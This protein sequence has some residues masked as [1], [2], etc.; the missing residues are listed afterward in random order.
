MSAPTPALPALRTAR[1][2]LV[3][4]SLDHL[5]AELESPGALGRL[6]DARVAQ[7]WPPGEYDRA[8]IDFF[9]HQLTVDPGAVGWYAWYAVVRAD[10]G[11]EAVLVGAGG[12]FGRPSG[13][14][15]VEI[16]YSIVPGF[17]GRGLATELTAA[18]ME[19]ALDTPGVAR[20]IAHTTPDNAASIKV[21]E[22]CGFD[23]AGAGEE[24]GTLRFVLG[25]ALVGRAPWRGIPT[26][27]S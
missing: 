23:P 4:A 12:F 14:G 17:R 21:L 6:L 2:D 24:P 10:A 9:R 3:A 11:R 25:A 13:D 27:A 20:I 22:R 8:A 7:G 5:N 15:V 16:G 26:R 18:L 1:L 19:F